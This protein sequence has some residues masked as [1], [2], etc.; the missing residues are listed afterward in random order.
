M[1]TNANKHVQKSHSVH[2]LWLFFSKCKCKCCPCIFPSLFCHCGIIDVIC[3]CALSLHDTDVFEF[4]FG[5]FEHSC[6]VL[7]VFVAVLSW[8]C[9]KFW[10]YCDYTHFW[11]FYVYAMIFAFW[12]NFSVTF[13]CL[14]S[15][16]S[17]LKISL[18]TELNSHSI[19]KLWSG[20]HRPV[21]WW[22][23]K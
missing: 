16:Q 22:P 14:V 11:S 18:H 21:P 9:G 6:S 19:Q 7:C 2:T 3:L 5:H 15:S 23:T 17:F 12:S 4:H 20:G 10:F 8:L 13:L 1:P